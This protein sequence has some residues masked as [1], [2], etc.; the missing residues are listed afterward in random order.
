VIL[1]GPRYLESGKSTDFENTAWVMGPDGEILHRQVKSVPVQFFAD[2]SPAQSRVP[3]DSPF[4]RLGLCICYDLNYR[5]VTDDIAA[6]GMQAL[7]VPTMDLQKWGLHQHELGARMTALRAVENGVP[8]FRLTSSGISVAALPDGK[9][10]ASQGFGERGAQMAAALPLVSAGRIPADRCLV[11]PAL[12]FA[13]FA[14]L[15]LIFRWLRGRKNRLNACG[16]GLA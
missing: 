7:I 11:W 2:G 6:A 13:F 10:A 15:F 8:V 1:G 12:G 9:I 16:Q 14:P 4:G 3:W 5:F